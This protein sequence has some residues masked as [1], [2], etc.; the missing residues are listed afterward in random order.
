MAFVWRVL[1]AITPCP[2]ILRS[3]SSSWKNA[4]NARERSPIKKHIRRCLRIS[5]NKHACHSERSEE[6]HRSRT[7]TRA[8]PGAP[9]VQR[10]LRDPSHSLRMTPQKKAYARAGVDVDLGNRLKRHIQLLVKRT[11]GLKVLG[12]IGGF[13]GLFEKR[14]RGM[15]ETVI[16]ERLYGFWCKSNFPL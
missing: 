4:N 5:S 15:Y 6:P 14:F 11:H 10:N 1:R 7:G 3:T 13:G 9:H 2:S 8:I 16:V 12:K